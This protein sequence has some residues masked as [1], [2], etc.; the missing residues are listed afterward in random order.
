MFGRIKT[1]KDLNVSANNTIAQAP[2]SKC[3]LQILGATVLLSQ[4][5]LLLHLPFWLTLPGILLV[6]AKIKNWQTDKPLLPPSL[7]IV[8]ILLAIIAVFANYGYLFGRDPCVAFL[9]L[10]LSFKYVETRKNYD[11]SLLIILCAFLL[12][13]QFFFRQSLVSAI[14]S[15]PSMYFIGLS[16]FVLQRGTNTTDTKTMVHIT[17]KLF[18]QAMP[19]A[20]IL[21]VA[22]PRISQSPWKGNGGG[23]ATTG[24]S[25]SMS[26]GSIASLSKSNEV[27]FRVEFDGEPPA[28]QDRY[29]R[30]PVLTGFDGHD[31]FVLPGRPGSLNSSAVLKIQA[32]DSNN[33]ADHIDYTVTMS[34]S[35][36]PWLLALDTPLHAP[37][38]ISNKKLKVTINDE[39]QI[40]TAKPIDQPLQYRAS[41]N[42]SQRFTPATRPDRATLITSSSNPKARAFAQELRGKYKDDEDLANALMHW[43]NR[44]PFYYTL[45][46]PK[47]GRNSIDDFIFNSRRGFCE[48]YAGS[49]VFMLRAAGIPARVVTG[50][51]GGEMSRDYMIVRQSDAH[52]WTEAYLNGQWQRFDPTG[53][54]APQRVEQGASEALRN[55]QSRSLI[56]KVE[57]PF[58]NSISL[59]WDAVN[60]AWQRM[61]IGFDSDRQSAMW[62][63]LGI[64]KPSGVM[65]VVGLMLAACLWALLILK[66]F[67]GLQREKLTP[68]EKV[69]RKLAHKLNKQGLRRH[70][71]ETVSDYIERACLVWPQHSQTLR[72]VANNYNEGIYSVTGSDPYR[73]Q[74]LATDMKKAVAEIGRLPIHTTAT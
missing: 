63:K 40:N 70:P 44:E 28:P 8:F 30:G 73:Q 49:F 50:Y 14:I 41:S 6:G 23:H 68:C 61:V 7:T 48:H 4:L 53:A 59:N 54:V 35:Y 69:W 5:P 27:A 19:I 52:A 60:F 22:V 42:I 10:L 12:V 15:I 20:L 34:A 29:W 37:V 58:L 43:F 17:A 24:L 72:K 11:A 31:W 32:A 45:N 2:L 65:I 47:L 56:D 13:T 57:I 71:G 62:K 36:Q 26:P 66:P 9:F 18:L 51:Q 3:T 25:A 33:T 64:D 46:P 74:T 38:P 21:F 67:A 16:L 55:D 39:L 1:Q